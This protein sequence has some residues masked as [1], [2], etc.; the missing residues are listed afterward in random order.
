MSAT[1]RLRKLLTLLKSGGLSSGELDVAGFLQLDHFPAK[2]P[3]VE[4]LRFLLI[5]HREEM[6]DEE[7]L[8]CN[9]RVRKIH[10]VASLDRL[11]DAAGAVLLRYTSS[12]RNDPLGRRLAAETDRRAVE[13]SRLKAAARIG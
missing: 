3:D 8:A 10:V 5:P 11:S 9:R 1:R 2:N 4:V 6:R 13:K 7:A 12:N